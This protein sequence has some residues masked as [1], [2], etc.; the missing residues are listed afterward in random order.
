MY[1]TKEQ[2]PARNSFEE[3]EEGYDL[4]RFWLGL[5]VKAV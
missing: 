2:I 4:I 5:A 1:V 3:E